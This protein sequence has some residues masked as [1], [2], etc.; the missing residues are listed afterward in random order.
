MDLVKGYIEKEVKKAMFR[1]DTNKSPGPDGFGSGFYKAAWSIVGKDITNAVLQ[2]L[3][4]GKLL[5]QMNATMIALI[6]KVKV[7]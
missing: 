1:I 2:S 4:N 7:P 3:R 6:P 5:K